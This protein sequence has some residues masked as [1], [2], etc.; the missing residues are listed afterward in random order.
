MQNDSQ[1]SNLI[2]HQRTGDPGGT[3]VHRARRN[4]RGVPFVAPD[5]RAPIPV[6]HLDL[7]HWDTS[8]L[9]RNFTATRCV[10]A[11]TVQMQQ[12]LQVWRHEATLRHLRGEAEA[13]VSPAVLE[14]LQPFLSPARRFPG[15][16]DEPPAPGAMPPQSQSINPGALALFSGGRDPRAHFTQSQWEGNPVQKNFRILQ[17][18]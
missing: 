18:K 3:W 4:R 15:T 8:A 12:E 2:S 6:A 7:M 10:F 13:L 14:R 11:A 17:T 5:N 1:P 9:E 16:P